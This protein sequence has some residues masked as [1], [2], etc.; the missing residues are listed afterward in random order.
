MKPPA[1]EACFKF[2]IRK[3]EDKKGEIFGISISPQIWGGRRRGGKKKRS[4]LEVRHV[5][6]NSTDH[7]LR[8]GR[9]E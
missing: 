4:G 1:D 5:G 2:R 9:A 6:E 8:M 7:L 3:Q